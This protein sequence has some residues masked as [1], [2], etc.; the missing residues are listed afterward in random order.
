MQWAVIMAGGNGTRF[1]PLSNPSHPK[2]F[3]KLLNE[4]STAEKTIER[5]RKVIP[6][7]RILM[8]SSVCHRD[9]LERALPDFPKS[10]ILWE[11]CG[12]NTAPCIA[13]ANEV[14][15]SRDPDA[16]VGVFASD[17]AIAEDGAFERALRD[18]YA[19]A[20]GRI[21]LFGVLPTRP[22]TGYGY[23]RAGAELSPGLFEVAS[24]LE[25][26]DART[27]LRYVEDGGYFWNSGMFIFDARTMRREFQ[28]HAPQILEG[29]QGIVRDPQT[30]D[31]QFGALPSISIDYAVMERTR[32]AAVLRAEFCWDDLGT[33]DAVARYF[34]SDV[35][36]NA[37][38]GNVAAL[39]CSNTFAFVEDGRPVA[40]LG[41]ENVTVVV[42]HDGVLVMDSRRAQDVKKAAAAFSEK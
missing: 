24:F 18:A 3:L 2:Q 6:P 32:C 22:E 41:L 12:R 14:I 15:L 37:A 21:I 30:L 26:P 17:H 20:R 8:V 5:V 7:E 23:I 11:P 9:A 27:A 1:W 29:V 31:V 4:H 28:S 19:L 38:R 25:K 42:T 13:W 36:G 33:W 10:Q 39:D 35:R 40:L 34:P 16:V